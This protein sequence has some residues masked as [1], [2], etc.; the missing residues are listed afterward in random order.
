MCQ[1]LVCNPPQLL[2]EC[3]SAL[4]R[5]G[6]A[7]T[8]LQNPVLP[9]PACDLVLLCAQEIAHIDAWLP[10]ERTVLVWNGSE[11]TKLAL[12]A[13][14]AGAAAANDEEI[15]LLLCHGWLNAHNETLTE[16]DLSI[17][18]MA[19]FDAFFEFNLSPTP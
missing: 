7:V 8:L 14:A 19:S 17:V 1:I 9:L 15:D 4:W 2:P 13:Y 3:V 10:I 12:A 16:Y 18:H 11:D 5:E 6:Y